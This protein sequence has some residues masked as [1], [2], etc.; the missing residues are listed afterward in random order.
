MTNVYGNLW[1][2]SLEDSNLI[3]K[4]EY[5]IIHATKSSFDKSFGQVIYEVENELFLNWVDS[6]EAKYFD[7]NNCGISV[8]EKTLNFIDKWINSKKIFV[9]CNEGISRSPSI[10]MVYMAKRMGVI[11]NKDHVFTEREFTDNF[12]PSYFAGKG[13]SDFLFKNWFKIK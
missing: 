8:F 10:I 5:A 3:N 6:K 7:F 2:G 1:V 4:K 11:T 9:H 12:Y 13:I